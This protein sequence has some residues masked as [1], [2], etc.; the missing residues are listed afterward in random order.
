MAQKKNRSSQ[1]SIFV[2]IYILIIAAVG[3]AVFL[4]MREKDHRPCRA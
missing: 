3:M 1:T 2:S 4:L